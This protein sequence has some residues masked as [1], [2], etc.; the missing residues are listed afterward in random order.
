MAHPM[1]NLEPIFLFDHRY[2]NCIWAQGKVNSYLDSAN[3][4][5]K[6]KNRKLSLE[7]RITAETDPGRT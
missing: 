5:H 2:P 3:Q 4:N 6:F 1:P 7:P